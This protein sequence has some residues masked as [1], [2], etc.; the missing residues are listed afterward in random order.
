MR[1]ANGDVSNRKLLDIDTSF[2]YRTLVYSI[3]YRFDLIP[4]QN[5]K[6]IAL[7]LKFLIMQPITFDPMFS[8]MRKKGEGKDIS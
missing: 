3:N 4:F 7:E 8:K 6:K 2:E 5:P 1:I